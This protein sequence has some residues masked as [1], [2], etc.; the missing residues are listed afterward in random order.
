M[1]IKDPKRNILDAARRIISRQ[2]VQGATIRAI[3]TEGNVS[4]GAVYH[5]YS[6]KEEILYGVMED[7]LSMARKIS[8]ATKDPRADHDK[9]I[10]AITDNILKRLKKKS[11]NRIQMY[12]AQEAIIGDVALQEKF[13]AKYGEWLG[14][15][16]DLLHFLYEKP[17]GRY[18]DA[19]ACL[20][21]GAVDGVVLQSLL[22]ANTASLEDIS[23]VFELLLKEGLS[24]FMDKLVALEAAED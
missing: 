4:T 12:L 23:K 24:E 5:Y 20:L 6:S 21:I 7:S 13:V 9:M 19:V 1:D 3:A 22:N 11:E 18:E 8:A 16:K 10:H 14:Q 2:G 17:R 15:T